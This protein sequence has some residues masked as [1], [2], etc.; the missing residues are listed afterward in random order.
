MHTRLLLIMTL[1][2][3]INCTTP[4]NTENDLINAVIETIDSKV[5]PEKII[6]VIKSDYDY[7]SYD[8]YHIKG[9]RDYMTTDVYPYKIMKLRDK[10]VFFFAFEDVEEL[11]QEEVD[12]IVEENYNCKNWGDPCSSIAYY[13]IQC[14]ETGKKL[15]HRVVNQYVR[16]FEVPE[17]R[18]FSC[19]SEYIKKNDIE[20][21]TEEYHLYALDNYALGNDTI[22]NFPHSLDVIMSVY[23]RSDTCLF[24]DGTNTSFGNFKLVNESDTL[25]FTA[26]L[27]PDSWITDDSNYKENP[28]KYF[29]L[30]ICSDENISFFSNIDRNNF[31]N[32]LIS[33]I[34]DSLYYFPNE[35]IYRFYGDKCVFPLKNIKV[36][37]PSEGRYIYFTPAYIYIYSNGKLISERK[38]SFN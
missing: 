11:L 33:L 32:N 34:Q 7:G 21:I 17:I 35:N 2:L 6:A 5:F 8:L 23:N 29:R 13:F 3:F 24:F 36:I 22:I 10:L 19:F 26:K 16:S 28:E 31:H 25:R 4:S 14:K 15:L 20:I 30:R 37:T 38:N 18:D 12:K 27:V 9:Y 1:V